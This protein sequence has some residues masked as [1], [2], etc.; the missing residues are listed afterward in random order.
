MS[1]PIAAGYEAG[2]LSFS[3]GGW[4]ILDSRSIAAKGRE[5]R[6]KNREWTRMNANKI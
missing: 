6:K 3:V 4:C 2:G 5:E 1:R